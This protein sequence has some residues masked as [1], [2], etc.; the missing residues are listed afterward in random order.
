MAAVTIA[1]MVPGTI[2]QISYKGSDN[3][4]LVAIA[5]HT[6]TPSAIVLRLATRSGAITIDQAAVSAVATTAVAVP[7]DPG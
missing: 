7:G 5:R 1:Q 6:I 4:A 3:R 2:Y